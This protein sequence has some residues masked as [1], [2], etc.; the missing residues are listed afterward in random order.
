MKN[1]IIC[2]LIFFL[3][4]FCDAQLVTVASE[5]KNFYDL[6]SL[7][8]YRSNTTVEQVATFDPYYGN[9][10]GFDGRYSFVRRNA[11]SSLVILD[12][13]GAGVINRIATPTPTHD[14]L[15]FYIDD[16]L[17]FSV[18]Y[19]DLFS[20]KIFP[21]VAPL[22]DSA[23]GGFYSYM[24]IPFQRS[25]KIV[26]RGKLL[27]FHQVQYRLFQ[28]GTIIESFN[29]KLNADSKKALN[30]I[31][32]AWDVGLVKSIHQLKKITTDVAVA[33]G[34]TSLLASFSKGGRINGIELSSA[35]S[36]ANLRITWDDESIAAINCPLKD[37]FGYA[38]GNPSMQGLLAGSNQQK[39]YC[40]IPMP[41]DRS[42]KIELINKGNETIS[43]KSTVYYSAIKRNPAT[44]GKL[45]T[46]YV[47][48]EL[49]EKDPFHVFLN[50]EGKGHYIGTILWSKGLKGTGTPF[51]E[52]D[53][54]TAT[55]GVYR[56]HGTGSEDYFNGGWYDVKGRW[57]SARSKPLSGC[58]DYS[59]KLERTGGYRFFLNDK[60]PFEK[61]IWHG[62][63]HGFSK[64]GF[65]VYYTSLSFYYADRPKKQL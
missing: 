59:S 11:D 58:L 45:Y 24:P 23:A 60:M 13:K 33:P 46:N 1:R 7:P 44:E 3:P 50:A 17:T 31:K 16:Q 35:D 2:L 32:T 21:F 51:F 29:I 10:D 57:D 18:C 39:N 22:C 36:N 12:I 8:V 28:V 54:S 42:A 27:Q 56:I 62:I 49:Y 26:C 65:P 47:Q 15:D 25:C 37:F 38:Y 48:H 55:D 53:D 63:E 14:T 40:Y 61:H 52:G 41:F 43:L 4:V 34:N 20:G 64:R 19:Y 30:K 9:N 6:S 5:L